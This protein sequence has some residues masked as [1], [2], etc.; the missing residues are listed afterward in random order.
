[1]MRI[2]RWALA[3]SLVAVLVLGI[4]LGSATASTRGRWIR[5]E[6]VNGSPDRV[7]VVKS[8]C[9]DAEDSAGH[10]KLRAFGSDRI[11]YGCYRRGY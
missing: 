8:V 9:L 1:M 2:A 5:F 4:L 3:V 11:V 7:L 10:L 6:S